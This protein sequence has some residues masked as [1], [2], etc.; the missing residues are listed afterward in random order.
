[1]GFVNHIYICILVCDMKLYYE[2]E[3]LDKTTTQTLKY[4]NLLKRFL[5]LNHF[6]FEIFYYLFCSSK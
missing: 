1:M 6:Y 3:Y 4:K 5:F 2:F